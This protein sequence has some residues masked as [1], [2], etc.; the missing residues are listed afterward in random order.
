MSVG[1]S[2][3]GWFSDTIA[4]ALRSRILRQCRSVKPS[5]RLGRTLPVG[6]DNRE[7][8]QCR[9]CA[10][11]RTGL[12]WSEANLRHTLWQHLHEVQDRAA[13]PFIPNRIVKSV[14]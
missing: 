14:R 3:A 1:S 2:I 5:R 9:D 4:D 11:F 12:I 6:D 8:S 10:T 13:I 7:R